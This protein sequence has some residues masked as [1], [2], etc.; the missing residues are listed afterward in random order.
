MKTSLYAFVVTALAVWLVPQSGQAQAQGLEYPSAWRCDRAAFNWYC[1]AEEERAKPA[2]PAPK[3]TPKT[4]AKSARLE[5]KDITTAEQLRLELKRR[6]DVAVM[7]PTPENVKDYVS[8]WQAVQEKGSVFADTWRRVVWQNPE[9]DYSSRRPTNNLAVRLDNTEREQG[10][11]EQMRRLAKAHGLIFFFRSD[12]PF[13]H[14][15]APMLKALKADF[16][17]DVLAVSI[18]GRGLKEFPDA[19]DGRAQALAWGVDRV[20]ALFIGSKESGERAPVGVGQMS[21]AE[22]VKRVFVLTGTK[23]GETF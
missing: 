18:D 15:M 2:D 20:P 16:G 23:P 10:Q 9:L 8:L 21:K 11:D 14:A 7:T 4:P 17:M 3:P 19:I 13:C 6:E 12:C 1:D 5:L 22:L